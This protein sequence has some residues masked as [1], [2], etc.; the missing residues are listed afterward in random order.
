MRLRK[1]QANHGAINVPK[2]FINE[3]PLKRLY[4]LS[5]R[6]DRSINYLVIHAILEFLDREETNL[7]RKKPHSASP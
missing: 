2:C 3:Q 6:K 4:E 5:Q 7:T 1:P